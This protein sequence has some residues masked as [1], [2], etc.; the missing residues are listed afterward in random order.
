MARTDK[1]EE[2]SALRDFIRS[3]GLRSTSPRVAVLRLLKQVTTPQSHAD[4]V[5]KLTPLGFDRGTVYR[6][7]VDMAEKGILTRSDLGDHVWRFEL[8]TQGGPKH[9]VVH[10]HFVCSDCGD[11]SCLPD[12]QVKVVSLGKTPRSVEAK[13]VE[14]QFKGLC[15]ACG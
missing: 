12:A 1:I 14:I 11:V 15:D 7:L 13:A 4:I 8:K 2:M 9:S 5:D 6:N 10:P 3:F